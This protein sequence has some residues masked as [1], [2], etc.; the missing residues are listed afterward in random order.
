M[1]IKRQRTRMV[2]KYH[3]DG[4]VTLSMRNKR[5]N[6]DGFL[7]RGS[8][9]SEDAQFKRERK[10]Q[11]QRRLQWTF[12][13]ILLWENNFTPCTV[14]SES[15]QALSYWPDTYGE[16]AGLWLKTPKK[17]QHQLSSPAPRRRRSW[18]L[19]IV[20]VFVC[21]FFFK[22]SKVTDIKWGKFLRIWDGA[23]E[24][25]HSLSI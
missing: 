23:L 6:E 22:E 24:G 19:I 1:V 10:E 14:L 11:L 16:V 7:T 15:S 21:F 13:H 18:A 5:A 12:L 9:Q 2:F 8:R 17:F 3:G 4:C 20:S 25:P